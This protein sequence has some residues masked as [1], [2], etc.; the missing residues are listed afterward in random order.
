MPDHLVRL[1]NLVPIFIGQLVNECALII[2][3]ELLFLIFCK[4]RE[5]KFMW[6]L[7]I[8]FLHRI[9]NLFETGIEIIKNFRHVME[10]KIMRHIIML[11]PI[12]A[13]GFKHHL[14]NVIVSRR[15]E[16]PIGNAGSVNL[17]GE[18][19][20]AGKLIE[21]ARHVLGEHARGVSPYP[22]IARQK[23][24]PQ[25]VRE[26]RPICRQLGQDMRGQIDVI[27]PGIGS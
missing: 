23:G 8:L 22:A 15:A 25:D 6:L 12:F 16:E 17:E 5:L 4:H 26:V 7:R 10:H 27:L 9:P 24:N 2:L 21:L 19:S 1:G 11:R 20:R 18:K 3:L 13:Q 14:G